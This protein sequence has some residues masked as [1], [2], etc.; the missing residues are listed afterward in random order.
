MSGT[1]YRHHFPSVVLIRIR[2]SGASCPSLLE[3]TGT[4]TTGEAVLSPLSF[5]TNWLTAMPQIIRFVARKLLNKASAI[6][7]P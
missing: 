6:L 7:I 1:T 5:P 3:Y 2:K 4:V